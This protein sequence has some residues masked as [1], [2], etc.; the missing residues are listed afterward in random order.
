MEN[1]E[2]HF[3]LVH[4]ACHGAWCWYKVLT[5]LKSAGHHHRVTAID[6]GASGVNPKR[7]DEVAS[8]SDYV[9]PLMEFMA[10]LSHEEKVVL[11]GHSYGGL[12]ISLAM[13]KFPEKVLVSVFV[14]A[15]MP[16]YKSPPAIL[17]QQYFD[18]T[19][20]ESLLD[21]HF[22]FENGLEN[23]P[24]SALFGPKYL[25]TIVY[26]HC[27]LEDLELGKMLVRQT[28]LF[29]GDFSKENLLTKE[30]FGSVD[31]VFVICKE[32]EVF[33]EEFQQMIINN[34]HPK[35]TKIIDGA[36]HMVMFSK[37]RELCLTLQDI[38]NK[39]N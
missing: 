27:P 16:H 8:V 18:S 6:L 12:C 37:P 10:S 7:L 36:G 3:V 1:H 31:R 24:T 2:K 38:A 34:Y 22:T 5:M 32:D 11:V 26:K 17:I 29:V 15:Y 25:K 9:Q 13:E 33:K 21:C 30:K 28:G 20:V 35:E 14:S 39:Y 4:G 19:P 23:R